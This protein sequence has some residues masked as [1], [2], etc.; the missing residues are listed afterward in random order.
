MYPGS[1]MDQSISMSRI[2]AFKTSMFQFHIRVDRIK[3][4][5]V[6]RLRLSDK[7]EDF[8]VILVLVVNRIFAQQ[9]CPKD[10]K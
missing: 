10:R 7:L 3:M 1:D 9:C 8:H 6:G 5:W 2:Y 4:G